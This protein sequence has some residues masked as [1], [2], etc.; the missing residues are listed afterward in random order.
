[1]ANIVHLDLHRIADDAERKI[2]ERRQADHKS[3]GYDLLDRPQYELPHLAL[4]VREWLLASLDS[5]N[6]QRLVNLSVGELPPAA[7]ARMAAAG[8][9][10]KGGQWLVT[11]TLNSMGHVFYA[12]NV[13]FAIPRLMRV[14]DVMR[15]LENGTTALNN[16]CRELKMLEQGNDGFIRS[17]DST[18][19]VVRPH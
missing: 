1:M 13:V 18:V 12:Q 8:Q 6:R 7:E 11:I 15:V 10:V 16:A 17:E 2:E 9:S 14:A 19:N 5:D 3:F 4:I